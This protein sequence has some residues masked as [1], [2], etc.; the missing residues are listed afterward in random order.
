MKNKQVK[1]EKSPDAKKPRGRP[2]KVE[3]NGSHNQ[4]SQAKD[5]EPLLQKII[6]RKKIVHYREALEQI[7]E[8]QQYLNDSIDYGEYVGYRKCSL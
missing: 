8:I 6:S 3:G 5:I 4:G 2:K 1:P 7:H